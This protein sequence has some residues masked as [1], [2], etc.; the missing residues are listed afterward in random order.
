MIDDW[1]R[2]GKPGRP[3]FLSC[4]G[5]PCFV[6]A[7]R[8]PQQAV[9]VGLNLNGNQGCARASRS[10]LRFSSFR[11]CVRVC[12]AG[13]LSPAFFF[14]F[15][16]FFCGFLHVRSSRCCRRRCHCRYT[17]SCL[18]SATCF[19]LLLFFPFF[20]FCGVESASQPSALLWKVWERGGR[21]AQVTP[22]F[23][24]ARVLRTLLGASSAWQ[25]TPTVYDLLVMC[26]CGRPPTAGEVIRR[27]SGRWEMGWGRSFQCCV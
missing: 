5:L 26:W 11:V 21:E 24:T 1:W 20:F 3:R 8:S 9:E 25:T 13:Y 6:V 19:A 10:P 15:F 12:S 23:G 14:F 7:W 17:E 22:P 18:C 16:C 27:L 2:E 4:C